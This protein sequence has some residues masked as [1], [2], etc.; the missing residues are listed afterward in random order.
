MGG[1]MAT[2]FLL[3]E[4]MWGLFTLRQTALFFWSQMAKAV[5]RL[6]RSFRFARS[7]RCVCA[8]NSITKFGQEFH[9]TV[10]RAIFQSLRF[11]NKECSRLEDK[12]DIAGLVN[13]SFIKVC[14]IELAR[15]GLSCNMF[16]RN[17]GSFNHCTCRNPKEDHNLILYSIF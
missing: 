15:S 10:R 1:L 13:E 8:V 17:V 9:K 4:R 2:S 7:K 14:R 3:A 11:R 12:H 5:I 6:F 16:L